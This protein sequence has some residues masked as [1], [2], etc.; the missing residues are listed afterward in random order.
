MTAH[1]WAVVD[2]YGNTL[3]KTVSETRRAALV[4]WLII[5]PGIVILNH[6]ADDMIE[7]LWAENKGHADVTKVTIEVES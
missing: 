1:G 2:R 6:Y 5:Y 3:V 7:R 4:N